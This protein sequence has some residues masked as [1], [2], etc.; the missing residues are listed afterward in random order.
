MEL[1]KLITKFEMFQGVASDHR[2]TAVG[3]HLFFVAEG[4]SPGTMEQIK[5]GFKERAHLFEPEA[6]LII[7]AKFQGAV[8]GATKAAWKMVEDK[9]EE[10]SSGGCKVFHTRVCLAVEY[11]EDLEPSIRNLVGDLLRSALDEMGVKD[12]RIVVSDQRHEAMLSSHID[13]DL[14]V[15]KAPDLEV[16]SEKH[17]EDFKKLLATSMDVED[18]L[19][20]LGG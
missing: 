12:F 16:I 14:E 7:L 9:I 10:I 6:E 3:P 11:E 2:L 19:K 8:S 15:I 5:K 17:C 20:A 4:L 13:P 1:K 18:V